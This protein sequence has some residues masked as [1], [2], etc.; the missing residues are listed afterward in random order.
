[1]SCCCTARRVHLTRL[2]G[3]ATSAS[4][5]GAEP[6]SAC[7][8][9]HKFCGGKGNRSLWPETS[10]SPRSPCL[11]CPH[12]S[13]S[14]ARSFYHMEATGRCWQKSVLS[15][16]TLAARSAD[17][18]RTC[19]ILKQTGPH[20]S[21]AAQSGVTIPSKSRLEVLRFRS[22]SEVFVVVIILI[23]EAAKAGGQSCGGKNRRGPRD[24]IALLVDLHAERQAHLREDFLDLIQRL[25]AEVLG[26]QHLGFGLLDKFADGGDVGV[27]QA[28]VAAHGEFE[29]LDR[30]V[31]ILVAQRRTVDCIVTRLNL[32]LEVD[33]DAHVVLQQ[34]GGKAERVR[35]EDGAVGP[36]FERELVVVG[37]LAEACG[38]DQVVDLA[39]R[40][41]DAVDRDKAQAQ[42]GIEVLV[43][44]DVPAAALEA[45]LHVDLSAFADGADVDLLVEDLNVAVGLDHAG[46]DN[47]GRV[48]AEVE[49]LGAVACKLEGNLLQVEDDVGGV[50]DH[51]A[52]GLELVQHALDPNGGNGCSL[53]RREQGAAEGVAYGG[54]EAALKWLG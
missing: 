13:Q 52:D 44:G 3:R 6:C 18:A 39:D 37:D 1:M 22:H 19:S 41:V 43:G 54:A 21:D 35:G 10:E 34:L 9:L 53:D 38:F 42:V 5:C 40:R 46:G 8:Q 31:E 32:F 12:S 47:A 7:S 20:P 28:V 36:D 27:L 29:L 4:S 45:H 49:G 2:S 15:N 25:A 30:A 17:C 11:Q 24:R 14:S 33:E 51:S 23:V 26:L 48:G 16:A 50:L